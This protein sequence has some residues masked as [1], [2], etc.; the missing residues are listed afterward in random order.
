MSNGKII[1]FNAGAFSL[2]RLQYQN[3]L[4]RQLELASRIEIM[5]PQPLKLFNP[6][7]QLPI[8]HS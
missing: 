5:P 6:K 8:T 2:R 3:Q 1:C 4:N 7:Y